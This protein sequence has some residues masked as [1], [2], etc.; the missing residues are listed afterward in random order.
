MSCCV[1]FG[2]Y[3]LATMCKQQR[4]WRWL[5]PGLRNLLANYGVTISI[6]V[7]TALSSLFAADV[8]LDKY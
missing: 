1:C 6:V 4:S 3:S 5:T 2:T 7:F 8:G